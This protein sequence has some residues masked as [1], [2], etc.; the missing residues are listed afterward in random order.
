MLKIYDE[1][2]TLSCVAPVNDIELIPTLSVTTAVK[3]IVC[4]WA[5]VL[6][7]I[8]VSSAFKLVMDGFWSSLFEMLIVTDSVELLPA[9]SPTVKVNVSVAEPKL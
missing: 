4:V 7:S 9:A 1:P 8:E 3:Y 5:E 2:L 6:S